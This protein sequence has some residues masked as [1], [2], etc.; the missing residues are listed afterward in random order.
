MSA[1][2]VTLMFV[3]GC[4]GPAADG[5]A[6]A[7]GSGSD[8]Q[9][10]PTTGSGGPGGASTGEGTAAPVSSFT[11][12]GYLLNHLAL[13]AEHD[14][15]GDGETDNNLPLILN[16][17]NVLMGTDDFSVE[18]VNTQIA[19]S[20]YPDNILLVDALQQDSTLTLDLLLGEDDGSGLSVDPASYDDAGV[21]HSRMQ[22]A[23]SDEI[24]FTV[25]AD[26]IEIPIV[27][28]EGVDPVPLRFE[29]VSLSG[30]L[31][32][33]TLDAALFGAIPISGVINDMVDPL[34]PDEGY[35]LDGD[36]VPEP[37]EEILDLVW[38]IA[39]SAG[40]IE[41]G[42]GETG[43]SALLEFQASAATF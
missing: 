23:F 2:I 32:T 31:D 34:I 30:E 16:L 25:D 39:P 33:A 7:N 9:G 20:L 18:S 28:F 14:T 37:K 5:D 12:G 1:R 43:V 41:L 13:V 36:G 3:L 26:A 15:D 6:T 17:V 10:L 8:T 21:P 4:S 40:D 22:G 42:D 11:S 24:R 19:E 27:I 38:S 35:D 29:V